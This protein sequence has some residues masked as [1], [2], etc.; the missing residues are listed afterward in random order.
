MMM[1]HLRHGFHEHYMSHADSR[2]MR[3]MT[4]MAMAM[5]TM[6]QDEAGGTARELEI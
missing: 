6:R 5:A 1:M 4:T 3:M 2:W